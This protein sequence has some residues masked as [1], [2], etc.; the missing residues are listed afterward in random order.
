[1]VVPLLSCGEDDD[2]KEGTTDLPAFTAAA[3]ADNPNFMEFVV[4]DGIEISGI[5]LYLIL[6]VAVGG[7]WPGPVDDSIFPKEMEV[8]YVRIFKKN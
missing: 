2:N 8:D 6:N 1:M 5:E 4:P 3:S 7:D